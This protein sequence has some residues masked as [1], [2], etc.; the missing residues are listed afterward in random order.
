MLRALYVLQIECWTSA[1]H[2]V[3][4]SSQDV[5][6][7][8]HIKGEDWAVEYTTDRTV[9]YTAWRLDVHCGSEVGHPVTEVFIPQA[10]PGDSVTTDFTIVPVY[11]YKSS[12]LL[13]LV[14]IKETME[15]LKVR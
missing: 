1:Q 14:K 2:C 9:I 12:Y 11:T 15:V 4:S 5:V 7:Q 3:P 13:H 10:V 6:H 8:S